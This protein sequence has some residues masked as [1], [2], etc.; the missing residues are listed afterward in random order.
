[1]VAKGAQAHALGKARGCQGT[2]IHALSD[3]KGRPIAFY[4]TGANVSDFTGAEI[5]LPLVPANGVL[6]GDKGY[7]S[8]R[9]RR[10]VEARGSLP[11]IPPCK[12]HKSKNCLSP[13]LYKGR[14]VI[15]RM[16]GRLKEFRRIATRSDRKATKFLSAICL[17]ATIC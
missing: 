5:L 3:N 1:M 16:F 14:N 2:K 7:D 13:C 17:A 10:T 15:E 4:L 6:H 9:I 12:T 11:N 8:D